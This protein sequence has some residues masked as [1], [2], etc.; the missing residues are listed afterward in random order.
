MS[1]TLIRVL[2][3]SPAAPRWRRLGALA[4]ALALVLAVGAGRFAYDRFHAAALDLSATRAQ[5]TLSLAVAALSG[6][7]RRFDRLSGLIAQQP[8]IRALL[9]APRGAAELQAANL[10]LRETARLLQASDIYVMGLDGTTLAA[11]NFDGPRSFVGGNFA[12]RPYFQDALTRGEGRFY[13]LGT[14]SGV[15]GYYFGAP[16]LIDDSNAGVL[17]IKIDLDAIEQSWRVRITR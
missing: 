8:V 6:Q 1:E 11:S 2:P 4:A 10:Y 5:N 17:A 12:F 15:R 14:T 13:A 3:A 16:V 9:F 7:L